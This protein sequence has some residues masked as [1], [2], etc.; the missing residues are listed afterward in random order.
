MNYRYRLFKSAVSTKDET[1]WT[2]YKKIRNEITADVR[3]AKATFFRENI[4]AAKSTAAYWKVLS[5]ATNPKRR[6][7]I[8]PFKRDD[9]TV[10]VR[11]EEK[12][13]LMNT[14]F[15]NVGASISRNSTRAPVV[16]E[17]DIAP[18]QSISDVSIS[19]NSIS[20]KIKALKVNKAEGPD[21]TTPKLLRLAEPAV[22]PSLTKLYSLSAKEGEVF[23]L[24]KK[25]SP[26]PS[27]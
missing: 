18:I 19:E 10:A 21:G 6:P 2:N 24:W 22:V 16:A 1:A 11:D 23:S 25:G 26:V 27:V 20:R 9:N 15:A 3:R 17:I 12:A 7:R 14:F 5:E 8:G 4:E 13:N